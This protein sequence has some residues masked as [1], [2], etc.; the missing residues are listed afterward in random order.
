M[1]VRH[2]VETSRET[3]VVAHTSNDPEPDLEG[4]V[5]ELSADG[6]VLRVYKG[7]TPLIQPVYIT[8]V[9]GHYLVSDRYNRHILHMNADLELTQVLI[10]DLHSNPLRQ[11]YCLETGKLYVTDYSETATIYSVC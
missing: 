5:S 11:C 8:T 6:H 1:F 7:P 10:A 3:F 2:A 9:N 4:G